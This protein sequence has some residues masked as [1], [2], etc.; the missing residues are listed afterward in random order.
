MRLGAGLVIF[1]G[2]VDGGDR[3][4]FLRERDH[5]RGHRF[6]AIY[7][8]FP[9]ALIGR[10]SGAKGYSFRNRT[11]STEWPVPLRRISCARS[12]VGWMLSRRLGPLI[13][14][15]IECALSVASS[16][17]KLRITI[18]IGLWIA[19]HRLA[20]LQ[21]SRDIPVFD[22]L[23]VGVD[24]NR[25]VEKIAD[26]DS[27]RAGTHG[28]PHC[29][30]FS[31]S[32]IRTSGWHTFCAAACDNVVDQVRIDRRRDFA[33]AAFDFGQETHQAGADRSFREILCGSS[34]CA[35]RG[36]LVG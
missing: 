32:T 9:A 7:D 19:K 21:E 6:Q 33:L 13:S 4:Q 22:G 11:S 23:L 1:A 16:R 36:S 30:T 26:E 15:Q 3:N 29:R 10:R 35:F 14:R 18:E 12:R 2:R 20:Q 17:V 5:L 31:P 24:V 27:L 34:G 28:W 25:E 8:P